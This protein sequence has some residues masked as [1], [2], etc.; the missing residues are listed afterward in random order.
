MPPKRSPVG[1]VLIEL[2]GEYGISQAQIAR[3]GGPDQ[4]TLSR[5]SRGRNM[6]FP[7]E[8]CMRAA[9]RI[10]DAFSQATSRPEIRDMVYTRVLAAFR[11]ASKE[12]P[13]TRK[14]IPT[15]E[16]QICPRKLKSLVRFSEEGMHLKP[17]LFGT[18]SGYNLMVDSEDQETIY[19]RTPAAEGLKKVLLLRGGGEF[20]LQ[21]LDTD[22][23]MFYRVEG[24]TYNVLFPVLVNWEENRCSEPHLMTLK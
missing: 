10:A 4:T 19:L 21:P 23:T 17:T 22:R 5:Y 2:T 20:G 1:I 13:S 11:E 18:G 3:S 24:L 7:E 12:M 14:R 16:N 9:A 15:A 8:T 6:P